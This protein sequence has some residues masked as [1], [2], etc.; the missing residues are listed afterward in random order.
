MVTTVVE[1][2][3]VTNSTVQTSTVKSWYPAGSSSSTFT[4]AASTKS[5][6]KTLNPDRFDQLK[7]NGFMPP[8][9]YRGR[10]TTATL[11]CG[12]LTYSWP[13][14]KGGTNTQTNTDHMYCSPVSKVP[15]THPDAAK[16]VAAAI[17]NANAKLRDQQMS[18]IE[19]IVEG[20]QTFNLLFGNLTRLYKSFRQFKRGRYSQALKTLGLDGNSV[21]S[22][23]SPANAWLSVRYGVLP[24]MSEVY[25]AMTLLTQKLKE[26]RVVRHVTGTGTADVELGGTSSAVARSGNHNCNGT[27][28]YQWNTKA[29]FKVA[30]GYV[31]TIKNDA[32]SVM[33]QLGLTNPLLVAEE[34]I[35]LSFVVDWF[36]NISDVLAQ[37]DAWSAASWLSGFTT[38]KLTEDTRFETTSWSPPAWE[39]VSG[40]LKNAVGTMHAEQISRIVH[41]KAPTFGLVVRPKLN[42]KRL[43]DAAALLKQFKR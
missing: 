17:A 37:L 21:K 9:P 4:F 3:T 24:L 30:V 28:F 18:L 34:L 2:A 29:T 14:G 6:T 22:G 1:P 33:T 31:Y 25:G 36:V 20:R 11:S 23:S 19:D 12:T 38:T 41:T 39:S 27:L 42:W 7:A 43:T 35:T 32:V 16:A 5:R 15:F 13:D 10:K 40:S 26:E 8:L